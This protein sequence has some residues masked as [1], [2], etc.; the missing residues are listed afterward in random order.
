MRKDEL[1]MNET[2]FY[3]LLSLLTPMHGYGIIQHVAEITHGRLTLGAGTTYGT[4]KKMQTDKLIQLVDEVD[5]RKI[6]AITDSGRELLEA[7]RGRLQEL[8]KNAEV[9]DDEG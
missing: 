2:A 7:E 6:Y 9:I 5:K 4:L 8:L 1:P 3:I